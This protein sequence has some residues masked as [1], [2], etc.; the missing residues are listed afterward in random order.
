MIS[1]DVEGDQQCLY[2]LN[3]QLSDFCRGSS[4]RVGCTPPLDQILTTSEQI[5][6]VP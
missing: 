1:D 4:F 6:K 2:G 5:S 3:S